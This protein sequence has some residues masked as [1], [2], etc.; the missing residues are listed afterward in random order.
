MQVPGDK[1]VLAPLVL[2]KWEH[3]KALQKEWEGAIDSEEMQAVYFS[4]FQWMEANGFELAGP[5][6]EKFLT[7]PA[8]NDKGEF[9]G[10]VQIIF[11]VQKKK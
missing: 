8:P 6:L 2:K 7:S 3:T 11:P 9:V 10:K 1:E 5:M 4:M